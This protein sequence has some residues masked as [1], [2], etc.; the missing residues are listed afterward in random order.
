MAF[1]LSSVAA[2]NHTSVFMVILIGPEQLTRTCTDPLVLA[3]R[4]E[5][6]ANLFVH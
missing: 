2:A 5:R 4:S 1:G 3:L 6:R